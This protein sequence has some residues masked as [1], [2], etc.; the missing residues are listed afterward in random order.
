[1]KSARFVTY[2]RTSICTEPVLPRAKFSM[3]AFNFSFFPQITTACSATPR[4]MR[5]VMNFLTG[6][7]P[8]APKK[9]STVK[10]FLASPRRLRSVAGLCVR[11]AKLGL[12]GKWNTFTFWRAMPFSTISFRDFRENTMLQSKDGANLLQQKP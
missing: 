7:T 6:P 2:P 1:M 11:R 9:K 3:S 8:S 10:G 5:T 12:I 4:S